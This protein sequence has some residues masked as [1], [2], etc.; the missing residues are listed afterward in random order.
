MPLRPAGSTN[1]KPGYQ[2]ANPV[3]QV[4]PERVLVW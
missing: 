2:V 4:H 3:K 1:Y